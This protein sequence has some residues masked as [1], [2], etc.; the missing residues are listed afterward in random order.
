MW[1]QFKANPP[2]TTTDF[3][4]IILVRYPSELNQIADRG[5]TDRRKL[6]L[7]TSLIPPMPRSAAKTL[8]Y[9]KQHRTADA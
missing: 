4:Y 7:P 6:L 9:P 2:D 5:L 8:A 1:G 3:E